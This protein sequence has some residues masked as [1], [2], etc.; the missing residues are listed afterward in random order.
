LK[1]GEAGSVLSFFIGVEVLIPFWYL[2]LLEMHDPGN[3]SSIVLKAFLKG[4]IPGSREKAKE[5]SIF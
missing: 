5:T 4:I 1:E 2:Q 3:V